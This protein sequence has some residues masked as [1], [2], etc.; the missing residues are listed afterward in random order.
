MVMLKNQHLL[1]D[2]DAQVLEKLE[3]AAAEHKRFSGISFKIAEYHPKSVV[4]KV[5][6]SK[7]A[8]G[9]YQSQKRLIEIVHETFDRFF[10]GRTIRV[11]AIAYQEPPAAKVDAKWV[12]DQMLA[13]GTKLKQIAKETG[14]DYTQLSSLISGIRPMS[15]TVKALFYFY[16]LNGK[17]KKGN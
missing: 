15:Q 5:V 17:V 10:P 6:Q 16:F 4:I 13:T 12:N 9:Q 3:H 7:T 8:F 2:I 14:I 11:H 1:T